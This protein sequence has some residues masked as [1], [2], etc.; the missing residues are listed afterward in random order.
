MQS[1]LQ[2]LG[3]LKSVLKRVKM[4]EH[5]IKILHESKGI[6]IKFRFTIQV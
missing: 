5:T 2:A 4:K 3:K 1:S 6:N